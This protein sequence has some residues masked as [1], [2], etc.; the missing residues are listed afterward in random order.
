FAK[1]YDVL[2][3]DINAERVSE[4]AN[5]KDRTQEAN[6]EDLQAVI[7]SKRKGQEA[8]AKQSQTGLLFSANVD[9]LRPYNTYSVTVPTPID[10][11]KA[12]DLT[13]L[14][15]ASEMLGSVLS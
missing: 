1:Q 12:P 3:F 8:G 14:I 7:T 11:F 15:K 6:L 10:Q 5:G 9:D 4:L 13:P 2:G